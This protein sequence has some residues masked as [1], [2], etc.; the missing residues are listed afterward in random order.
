MKI[1]AKNNAL[2]P[3]FPPKKFFGAEDSKFIKKRQTEISA[4]FENINNNP[5]F[6]KLPSFIKFVKEKKKKY[7]NTIHENKSQVK[8]EEKNSKTLNL[9]REEKNPKIISTKQIEE[10]ELAK[11]V[12]ETKLL[13]Y[14]VNIIYDKEMISDNDAF[15]KF[16]KNNTINSEPKEKLS[17]ENDNDNYFLIIG[18]N[19][20]EVNSIEM[21]NKNKIEEMLN[22]FK[23][24][25]YKFDTKGIVSEI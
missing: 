17:L 15:V 13:F 9:S 21:K 16:F 10:K 8:I 12:N 3:K 24:L 25:D 6:L 22:T 1:E 14:D 5:D 19:D 23:S 7:D 11:I 18:K 4:F 2:F 20:E